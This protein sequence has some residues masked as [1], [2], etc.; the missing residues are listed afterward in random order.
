[1]EVQAVDETEEEERTIEEALRLEEEHAA[2]IARHREQQLD[3][4]R[5]ATVEH[6]EDEGEP[7]SFS[8]CAPEFLAQKMGEA[9]SELD[10][11]DV[12][13]QVGGVTFAAHK[14]PLMIGSPVLRARF[15]SLVGAANDSDGDKKTLVRLEGMESHIFEG[16]LGFFYTGSVELDSA[17]VL[18]TLYAADQLQVTRLCELCTELLEAQLGLENAID[19]FKL[20]TGGLPPGVKTE[21]LRKA[22][23]LFI[24][25]HFVELVDN[26]I[27]LSVEQMSRLLSDDALNAPEELVFRTV[28]RWRRKHRDEK[29]S[30]AAFTRLLR[31]VRFPLLSPRFL[32]GEARDVAVDSTLPAGLST[33]IKDL[34]LEGFSVIHRGQLSSTSARSDSWNTASQEYDSIDG[35]CQRKRSRV[36]TR[37]VET[38]FTCAQDSNTDFIVHSDEF[39]VHPGM[40]L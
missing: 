9:R 28:V 10:L 5:F 25:R 12:D 1:M 19:V 18:P 40:F 30:D 13:I 32:G 26:I 16:V 24:L 31:L 20:A 33:L 27:E 39:G 7:R 35:R 36:G 14:F 17:S 15:T 6:D 23:M 3:L 22:S 2:F 21:Q 11:S 4:E 37:I 34:I 8:V 38:H 29:G